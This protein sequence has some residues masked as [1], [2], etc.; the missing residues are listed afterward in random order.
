MLLVRREESRTGGGVI[1]E[2]GQGNK[3]GAG[4]KTFYSERSIDLI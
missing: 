2:Q 1:I 3:L 4:E